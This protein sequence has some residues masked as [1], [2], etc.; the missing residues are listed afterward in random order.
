MILTSRPVLATPVRELEKAAAASAT[1]LV[2]K[3]PAPAEVVTLEFAEREAIQ[4]AS[5][6]SGGRVSGPRGAATLLGL[7]RTTLQ[8]RMAKLGISKGG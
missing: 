5:R 3:S 4:R 6:R 1:R 7:K 8:A 2:S